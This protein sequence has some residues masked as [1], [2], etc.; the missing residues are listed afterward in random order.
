MEDWLNTAAGD[1]GVDLIDDEMQERLLAS[2]RRG[3]RRGA[4][5]HPDRDVHARRGRAAQALQAKPER[6]RLQGRSLDL[7]R[8]STPTTTPSARPPGVGASG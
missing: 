3:A 8:R 1:L 6:P 4:Q 7:E 5:A 2:P